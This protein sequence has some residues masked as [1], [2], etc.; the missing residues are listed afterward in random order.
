MGGR[1]KGGDVDFEE[2]FRQK[3]ESKQRS[4]NTAENKPLD[5]G[6]HPADKAV[7]REYRKLSNGE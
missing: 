7:A 2:Y 6:I 5:G 4:Y 1:K 3:V